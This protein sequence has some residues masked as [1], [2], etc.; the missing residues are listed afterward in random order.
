MKG[1]H[2]DEEIEQLPESP[3]RDVLLAVR[4]PDGLSARNVLAAVVTEVASGTDPVVEV[5]LDA[6]GAAL[7]AEITRE[8]LHDLEITPG[9]HVYV[10]VKAVAFDRSPGDV[11]D[12]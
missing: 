9:R 1:V 12:V 3:A 2:P 6:G 7:L 11:V 4:P 10:V 5:R 8:A